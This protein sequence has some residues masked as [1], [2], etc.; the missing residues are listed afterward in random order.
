MT[1]NHVNVINPNNIDIDTINDDNPILNPI[2][3]GDKIKPNDNIETKHNDNVL[4]PST[5]TMMN[6]KLMD[7]VIND[8]NDIFGHTNSLRQWYTIPNN[9]QGDFIDFCYK[10][11]NRCKDGTTSD[12]TGFEGKTGAPQS[13]SS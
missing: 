7:N 5:Q 8:S 9:I 11:P 4:K 13:T 2:L 1:N 10:N 12:C 6:D 3:F